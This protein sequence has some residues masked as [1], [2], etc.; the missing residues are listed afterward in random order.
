MGLTAVSINN[1]GEW[2]AFGCPSNQQLLVWEW[3]SETYV[4]KQRGH[5][6]GMRCMSYSP[7]GIVVATGGEDGSLKLWNSTSGFCY[8]TLTSHTAPITA[9]T[10]AGSSVVLTAS[11]DGTV[12]AH[13][14]HRTNAYIAHAGPVRKPCYR[15]RRRNCRCRNRRPLQRLRME[16]S[17]FVSP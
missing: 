11:L 14:L 6:Y 1:T 2:L 12:R 8:C 9:T 5:A 15:P 10:F 16:S 3:R 4:I 7:D 13:D 17:E